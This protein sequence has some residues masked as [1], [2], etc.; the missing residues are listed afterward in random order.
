[1]HAA[2][3]MWVL[4]ADEHPV[5]NADLRAR[6]V[7]GYWCCGKPLE[8]MPGFEGNAAVVPIWPSWEVS[9]NLG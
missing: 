7:P 5:S 3:D 1:M 8:W 6:W 9:V 4:A 2:F